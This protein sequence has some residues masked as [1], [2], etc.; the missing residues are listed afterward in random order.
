MKDLES[1]Q[2]MASGKAI[3]LFLIDGIPDG[4][5]ACELFNWIGKGYK[6]PR[7]LLKESA[8]REDLRKAGVYFL[9]GRDEGRNDVNS[10]YIGEA[11]EVYKR[12]TQH[13]EKDFW[14]EVL[15]FIS[16][17]ENLNKAHIKFLEFT[18]YT[19]AERA[20]RYSI[21]NGNTPNC[22]AISELEQAVMTEFFE[23][24]KVL[25]GALGYKL[26][27]SLTNSVAMPGDEYILVAARGANAKAVLTSDGMVVGK[28]SEVAVT[29]VPSTPEPVVRLRDALLKD[30]VLVAENGKFVFARDHLFA[31]PSTAASVVLGRSANGR[32]EWKDAT[33]KTLKENEE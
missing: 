24:L 10:V 21:R 28:G 3:S 25:V 9:F 14:T 29:T 13:Q 23:N 20:N 19:E 33:G 11:E 32:I 22:P 16:K 26:F 27:E 2:V 1:E 30:G 31:S 17:D 5:V 6:I 18:I 12:I 4:R 7:R 8:D 15:L